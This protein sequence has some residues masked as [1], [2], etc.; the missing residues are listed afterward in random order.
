M[1]SEQRRATAFTLSA[2]LRQLSRILTTRV[3]GYTKMT[4]KMKMT[5]VEFDVGAYVATRLLLR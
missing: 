4:S 2:R 1:S 5:G 3:P